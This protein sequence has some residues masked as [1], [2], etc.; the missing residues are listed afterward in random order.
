MAYLLDQALGGTNSKQSWT[1]GASALAPI[2]AFEG[3]QKILITCTAGSI[4]ATMGDAAVSAAQPVRGTTGAVAGLA[5]P[6]S[7]NLVIPQARN[8]KGTV[9]STLLTRRV[10]C[11][12]VATLVPTA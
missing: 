12:T 3:T 10:G 7:P 11:L 6:N 9:L 2:G 4:D 1:I 5:V 8:R